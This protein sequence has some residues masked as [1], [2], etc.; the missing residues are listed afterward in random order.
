MLC[1]IE[2]VRVESVKTYFIVVDFVSRMT[3][4][5]HYQYGFVKFLPFRYMYPLFRKELV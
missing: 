2:G 4:Y 3:F 5:I 1:F